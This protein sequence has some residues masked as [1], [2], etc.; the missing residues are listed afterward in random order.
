MD[1]DTTTPA[2][3]PT[4]GRPARRRA[5]VATAAA[6]TALMPGQ[7]SADMLSGGLFGSLLRG[8]PFTGPRVFDLVAIG[9]VI[10]LLLRLVL[11]RQ[12]PGSRDQDPVAPLDRPAPTPRDDDGPS[13]PDAPRPKPDMYS[14]AAATWAYLQSSPAKDAPGAAGDPAPPPG[15]PGSDAEF[16][17]GAKLAYSRIVMAIAKRD[18]DD[19]GHFLAPEFLAR[20]RQSLPASPPP[21]PDILLVEARLADKRQEAGRTVMLVDYDVLIHEENAPHNVDRFERWRF[22]RDDARPGANWLLE[23]RERRS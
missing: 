18:F 1:T 9:L 11:G 21:E 8:D 6:L 17:A 19:L 14:N 20:L 2:S 13:A 22:S 15:A 7:A 4:G 3:R 16:L 5:L 10:F 23:D 12:K